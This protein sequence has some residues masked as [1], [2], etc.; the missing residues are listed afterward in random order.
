VAFPREGLDSSDFEL[1]AAPAGI[2]FH[3][4]E[5]DA[6]PFE[7]RH[8]SSLKRLGKLL[9][10]YVRE[11]R[12]YHFLVDRFG[13]VYRV[14]EESD[15]AHHAGYS[16]WA[17]ADWLYLYLN[18]SFLSVAFESQ[19]GGMTPAQL[20]SGRMLTEMLRSK[21]HIAETN[22]VTHAQVSVNPGNMRIGYHTDWA[23]DFPFAQM[24]L[25]NNYSHPLPA[26]YLLGFD[27]DSTYL[28]ASGGMLRQALSTS[29]QMV[30]DQGLLRGISASHYK[31]FLR[32]RYRNK[33]A[34]LK[35]MSAL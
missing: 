23:A 22:C 15:A 30:R 16:V 5:S 4:T 33:T 9:L 1:R 2:V 18:T 13:R 14:V 32:Q 8:N 11:K 21:Y 24:G 7:E 20:R 3:S 17:D 28:E 34:A 10:D 29:E 25:P 12:A 31:E 19:R 27:Y 6:A 26:L 35:R